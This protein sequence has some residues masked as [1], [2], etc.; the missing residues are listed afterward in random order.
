MLLVLTTLLLVIGVIAFFTLSA[1]G[2]VSNALKAFAARQE[3]LFIDGEHTR[4][5]VGKA[6]IE[7]RLLPHL[8]YREP[9]PSESE[10]RFNAIVTTPEFKQIVEDDAKARYEARHGQGSWEQGC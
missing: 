8:G 6:L 10:Q 3:D 5:Y 4:A 1:V 9:V 2:H 7:D